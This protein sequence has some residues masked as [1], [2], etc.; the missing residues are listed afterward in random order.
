MGHGGGG[1][2]SGGASGGGFNQ[3]AGEV[4][5]LEHADFTDGSRGTGNGADHFSHV[6]D[7]VCQKCDR[8]IT[9]RQPAR[10][11][12]EDGWVHDTCPPAWD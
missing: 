7:R 4:T 11:K 10:R 1:G 9:A 8:E 5:M 6:K 3:L 12:G 2:G